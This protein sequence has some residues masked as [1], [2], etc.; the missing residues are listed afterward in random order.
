MK[1]TAIAPSNIAFI[2]FWGKKNSSLVL[3]NNSSFSMCLDSLFTTTTVEFD[4][5]YK[6]D[7][8]D[9]EEGGITDVEKTR[10]FKQLGLIRKL[11]KS[12]LNA[13]VRTQNNFPKSSGIASSASGMAALTF[14]A[15]SSLE[16]Y[17][18]TKELSILSRQG[19]GSASRSIPDGF[20]VWHK[21]SNN[22]S[23]AETLKPREY[24]DLQDVVLV[25]SRS[26][27]KVSSTAGHADVLTSP[28]YKSRI[29]EAE[30]NYRECIDSF[31]KKDFFKFAKI[32]EKDC[33]SMH[34]VMMTQTPPLL[35]FLPKTLD[36]IHRVRFLREEKKWPVCFTID[37][38]PNVHVICES[39]YAKKVE[40]YFKQ[41]K[42]IE[43]IFEA[44]AGQGTRLVENHLF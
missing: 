35:Y 30:K 40:G 37:A 6:A 11:A 12:K 16:L 4:L 24:W 26:E 29:K 32:V 23:F 21:G 27:K 13:K 10:I 43:K 34:S 20:V 25:V 44:K 14:A 38:G 1:S 9:F 19:S 41:D 5:K 15:C 7:D 2:K 28:F 33:L 31:L 8:F 39:E 17:L 36:I 42:E 18:S 3:P 22:N